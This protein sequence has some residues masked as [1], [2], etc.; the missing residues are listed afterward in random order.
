MGS[1]RDRNSLRAGS[2]AHVAAHLTLLCSERFV[3]PILFE[4]SALGPGCA[5]SR[6]DGGLF[7]PALVRLATHPLCLKSSRVSRTVVSCGAKR[8]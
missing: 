2:H 7:V 4:D 8:G 3:E 5:R 6:R 1:P